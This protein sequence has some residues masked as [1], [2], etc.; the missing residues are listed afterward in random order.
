MEVTVDKFGRVVLPK[1]VRKISTPT[2]GP[3]LVVEEVNDGILLK[4]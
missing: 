1:N 2:P 3:S 4:R